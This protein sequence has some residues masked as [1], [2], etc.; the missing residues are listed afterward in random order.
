MEKYG[1]CS[2]AVVEFEIC[3]L[4]GI[5]VQTDHICLVKAVEGRSAH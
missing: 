2:E 3:N 5:S 1:V 4:E